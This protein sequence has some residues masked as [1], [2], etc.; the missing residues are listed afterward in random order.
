MLYGRGAADTGALAAM[1]AQA[2]TFRKHLPNHQ[3]KIALLITSM[4][5]QRL[6]MER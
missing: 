2:E 3:G 4:K 1:P 6:S 5:R